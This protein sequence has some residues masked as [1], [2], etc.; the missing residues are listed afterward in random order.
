MGKDQLLSRAYMK[1]RNVSPV[2]PLHARH[3]SIIPYV[4]I[5]FATFGNIRRKV[6]QFANASFL[7]KQV[8]IVST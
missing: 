2:G 4:V 1:L 6:V 3:N 8:F 7:G 5:L